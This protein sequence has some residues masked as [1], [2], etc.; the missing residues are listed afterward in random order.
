M[1]VKLFII[2]MLLVTNISYGQI[3]Q[4]FDSLF[5]SY[6]NNGLFN[7]TVLIS[8]ESGIV[9]HQAFGLASQEHK[10]LNKPATIFRLGSLEKQFTAMLIMQLVEKGKISLT[11][12]ITDYLPLYRKVSAQAH[13]VHPRESYWQRYPLKH[14]IL[15]PSRARSSQR[16]AAAQWL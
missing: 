14:R 6:H 2:S 1:M 8:N 15:H 3:A 7:G 16:L 11:G 10:I 13:E 12:K 4:R 5:K 9:Y